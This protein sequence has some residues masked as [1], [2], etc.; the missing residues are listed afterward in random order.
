MSGV[1]NLASNFFVSNLPQHTFE[2]L[3]ELQYFNISKND[4]FGTIPSRLFKSSRSDIYDSI[5]HDS[6][7]N[8]L[9]ITGQQ[10]ITHFDASSNRLENT[11]PTGF[12]DLSNMVHLNLQGNK[13]TGSLP[14]E[15]N[16]LSK[17]KVLVLSH[18]ELK[19][20]IPISFDK[21]SNVQILHLHSNKL[22]GQAPEK[23][24]ELISYIT[25]CGYPSTSGPVL[26]DT[27]D[28]CCNSVGGCQLKH[29]DSLPP[30]IA[31]VIF[32]FVIVG[33]IILGYSMKDRIT[34]SGMLPK[35]ISSWNG[36]LLLSDKSVYHFLLT[37]NSIGW[38]IA[39]GCGIVQVRLMYFSDYFNLTHLFFE[40]VSISLTIQLICTTNTTMQIMILFLFVHA[41]NIENES[42]DWVCKYIIVTF[43][44][45]LF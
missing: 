36:I 18:N 11:I 33:F 38:C 44:F 40:K 7:G 14:S 24:K 32:I 41:A 29:N 15:L 4:F 26:C 16:N 13:L 42:S 25:D 22:L 31:T 28:K 45:S 21:L 34:S 9:R 27:C 2:S 37:R 6:H 3:I 10:G 17:L 5:Y 43:P 12:G 8:P 23:K 1:L 20:S 19:G 39:F 35:K 30:V